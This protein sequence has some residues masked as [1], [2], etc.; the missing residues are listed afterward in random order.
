MG[1]FYR[2][3]AVVETKENQL[4]DKVRGEISETC[5]DLGQKLL[6]RPARQ[7]SL[8]AGNETSQTGSRAVERMRRNCQSEIAE[9]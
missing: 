9:R 1:S 6:L 3:A 8:D 5:A 7:M 4:D 2:F